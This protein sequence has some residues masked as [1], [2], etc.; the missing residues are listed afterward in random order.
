MD[1][2]DAAILMEFPH[3]T[4]LNGIEGTQTIFPKFS[5]FVR[6]SGVKNAHKKCLFH[7]QCT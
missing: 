2:L 4:E 5:I 7:F 1:V 3:P 6:I